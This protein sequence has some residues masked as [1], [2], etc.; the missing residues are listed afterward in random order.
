MT[1]TSGTDYIYAREG[2]VTLRGLGAFDDL[3]GG[4]GNDDLDGGPGF[5]DLYGGGGDDELSDTNGSLTGHPDD[6][7]EVYG[8]AGIDTIDVQD[9]DIF[10]VVCTGPGND[11]VPTTDPGDVVDDPNFGC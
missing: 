5:D 9:G 4:P 11:P 10:D 3:R 2:S 1:G 8:G 7:D 6:Y